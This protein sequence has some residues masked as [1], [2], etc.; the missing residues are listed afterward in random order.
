MPV[1]T[2]PV[3]TIAGKD[4]SYVQS[5]ED[6]TGEQ[7][8]QTDDGSISAFDFVAADNYIYAIWTQNKTV[9]KKALIQT[10]KKH[11]MQRT[12]LPKHSFIQSGLTM[13]TMW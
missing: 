10:V 9:V 12:V 1:C 7:T 11:R 3:M 13:Q 6:D 8:E 5:S 2:E 4:A